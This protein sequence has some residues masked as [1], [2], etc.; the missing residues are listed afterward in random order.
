MLK[1]CQILSHALHEEK[2]FRTIV[3]LNPLANQLVSNYNYL[4]IKKR[5]FVSGCLS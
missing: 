4:I 2:S 1:D 3:P 5:H